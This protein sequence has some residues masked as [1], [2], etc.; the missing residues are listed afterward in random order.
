MTGAI[1]DHAAPG[2]ASA[3]RRGQPVMT[4][5][6][7]GPAWPKLLRMPS[8]RK[9]ASPPVNLDVLPLSPALRALVERVEPRHY[10]KNT[11]LIQEGDYG[12]TIYVVLGG[13]VKAYSAGEN[14]REVIYGEYGPGDYVGEM[15]LD[16]GPRSANVI[17]MASTTCAVVT[18]QTLL[19]HVA[20]YP[21]FAIELLARVIRRART[22]TFAVRQLALTDVYGRLKALL[23]E[24]AERDEAGRLLI[25]QHLTVAALA[26]RLGCSKGMISRLKKDLVDGGYI[27]LHPTGM[28][29]LLKPLPRK[30]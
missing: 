3:R 12:D 4:T 13:R 6:P 30:W 5:L 20:Q 21:E 8:P 19:A 18:R 2:T 11:L 16:G 27:A 25:R 29:E 10:P 24:L 26:N 15:S 9:T 22:T 23:E 17:T 1:A 14:D 28:I 7:Q